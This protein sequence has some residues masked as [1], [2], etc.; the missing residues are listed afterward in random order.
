M[1]PLDDILVWLAANLDFVRLAST[2]AC[3]VALTFTWTRKET[4]FITDYSKVASEVGSQRCDVDEYDYIIVGGGMLHFPF[5]PFDIS[6]LHRHS[7]MRPCFSSFRGS[8][9]S[10]LDDRGWF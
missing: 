10:C 5:L 6:I 4:K 2:A 9:P 7:R 1:A 8:K 3:L